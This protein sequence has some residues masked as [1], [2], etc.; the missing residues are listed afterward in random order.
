MADESDES[1]R[2]S[3]SLGLTAFAVVGWLAAGF[4]WWQ[5][6]ADPVSFS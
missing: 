6:A 1:L 5:G 3:V 4:I 2:R